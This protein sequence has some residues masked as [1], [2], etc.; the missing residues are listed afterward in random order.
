MHFNPKL[1]LSLLAT[2]PSALAAVNG[3]CANGKKG[4]CISTG[5][6]GSYK[7]TTSNG[8]C[9]SDPNDVKCCSNIPCTA[10]GMNGS[11]MFT[12]ECTDGTTYSGLCPGGSNFK[13][14]IKKTQVT[15]VGAACSDQGIA[16][17]CINTSNTGCSTTL[18]SGKCPGP[19]NVKCCLNSNPIT[20]VGEACSDQG[21]AGK[22]INTSNTGCSTTLVSGRCPGPANVK[23]CLNSNPPPV[24]VTPPPSSNI[25]NNLQRNLTFDSYKKEAMI[26]AAQAMLSAGYDTRFIAGVLGNIQ[27]EGTPGKFESSNYKSNPSAEPAYLK[28]MDNN[29]NYRNLYSGR[30]IT[31]V[32]IAS[33]VDIANKAKNSGYQGK[34]GLGMIQWTGGRTNNLLAEYQRLSTS[35]KPSLNECARIEAQFMVKELQSSSYSNI[36]QTWKS[37]PTP[38][39]AGYLVCTKY[40]IPANKEAQGQARGNNAEAIYKKM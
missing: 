13:C 25:I 23:C 14:C 6:C 39:N 3:A 33:A 11:C 30:S 7:G 24:T 18:V 29:F 8:N 22:C 37:N 31:E 34:F 4:I 26:A 2:V 9:P 32:G 19:A 28:Y 38:Y 5:S 15:G 12:S 36:Y 40:E 35:D 27:N 10:N 20:G 16:G 21:I 1:I 17:K